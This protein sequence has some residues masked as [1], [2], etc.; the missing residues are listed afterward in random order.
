MVGYLVSGS[1]KDTIGQSLQF[2]QLRLMHSAKKADTLPPI[3]ASGSEEESFI[4]NFIKE[5]EEKAKSL[6]PAAH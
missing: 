4:L 2:L 3:E 5:E 6:S 1:P